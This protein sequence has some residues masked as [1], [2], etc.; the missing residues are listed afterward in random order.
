MSSDYASFFAN[1]EQ[2]S[3][4]NDSI[5]PFFYP[6]SAQSLDDRLNFFMQNPNPNW[7]IGYAQVGGVTSKSVFPRFTSPPGSSTSQLRMSGVLSGPDPTPN[8]YF[9]M[10]D[11]PDPSSTTGWSIM[12]SP[13]NSTKSG[14]LWYKMQPGVNDGTGGQN[15]RVQE[16]GGSGYDRLICH[17][18]SN[19][20]DPPPPFERKL[21]IK[22][23]SAG[24]TPT[25]KWRTNE[26]AFGCC[27]SSPL[28]SVTQDFQQRCAPAFMPSGAGGSLCVPF[29]MGLCE[30]NWNQDYCAEYLQSFQNGVGNSDV[31]TVFQNATVNYINNMAKKTGCGTNDYT[32]PK[33]GASCKM[34]NGTLRDDGTD[35]FINGTMFDFCSS[36]PGACTNILNQYCSQFTRGDLYK[37]P[38]LQKLCGCHMSDGDPL[39]PGTTRLKLS[40]NTRQPN[41]YVYPGLTSS[42]DPL[43]SVGTTLQSTMPP[44]SHTVCI[45]DNVG[46]NLINSECK[47]VNITQVCGDSFSDGGECYMSNTTINTINSQCGG[48]VLSQY[49]DTCYAYDPGSLAAAVPVDCKN[50]SGKAGPPGFGG[51]GKGGIGASIKKWPRWVWIMI[52]AVVLILVVGA[53]I[54][55]SKGKDSDEDNLDVSGYADTQSYG[56][57]SEFEISKRS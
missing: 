20:S 16:Q 26:E 5:Y 48:A 32:S 19:N 44:C 52:V 37:A 10:L 38:H 22:P 21:G 40:N 28:Q 15:L 17:D 35:T 50:P 11:P 4:R 56:D 51:G 54:Y 31:A 14:Y 49:C 55:F 41:Q 39:A 42:C 46:I 47:D 45:M 27:T 43:C 2:E 13:D 33:L 7:G 24:N 9:Y 29:M 23:I 36:N 53:V 3:S 30:N 12:P 34:P 25:C 8:N 18:P 6:L 57:T 1:P